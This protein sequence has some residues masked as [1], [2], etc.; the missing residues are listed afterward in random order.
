MPL[1]IGWKLLLEL[2]GVL[3][4]AGEF[5]GHGIVILGFGLRV[6]RE[7]KDGWVKFG[8]IIST[9]MVDESGVVGSKLGP[10]SS[11]EVDIH[12][13]AVLIQQIVLS[14]VYVVAE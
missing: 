3:R 7:V 6:R 5:I 14:F 9:F 4:I 1:Q 8:I 12:G 2:V 13:L 10:E 11:I